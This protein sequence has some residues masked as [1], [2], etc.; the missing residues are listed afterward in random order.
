M[1]DELSRKRFSRLAVFA[2]WIICLVPAHSH[3]ASFDCATKT[4][5]E[6]HIWGDILLYVLDDALAGVREG[7]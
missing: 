6:K 5:V 2:A 3:A 7:I 4:A 1:D